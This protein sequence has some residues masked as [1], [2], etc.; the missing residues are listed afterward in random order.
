VYQTFESIP[1]DVPSPCLLPVVQFADAPGAPGATDCALAAGA[2][3]HA[4]T[5]ATMIARHT[6]PYGPFMPL[7]SR[8]DDLKRST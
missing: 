5:P 7:S 3:Q 1:T 4:T 8:T 2:R 6:H